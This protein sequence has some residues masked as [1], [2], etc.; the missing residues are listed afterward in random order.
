MD[1]KACYTGEDKTPEQSRP[2]VGK[3]M[4]AA[5]KDRL[6]RTRRSFT[7]PCSVVKSLK[8][9][10]DELPQTSAME[11]TP[12]DEDVTDVNRNETG[13]EDHLK[14]LE[15]DCLQRSQ[16]ELLQL[17]EKLKKDVKE[18][19][20][21]LRRLNM[22]KM[23]RKKNDLTQLQRLIDK[24]RKCAQEALYEL[25]TELPTNDQKA[26]LSQLIDHFGLEDS[27]LHFNRTEEDFTNG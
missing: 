15:S 7:S 21:M 3:P 11:M 27:I 2:S 23:Y 1:N 24:W 13:R 19:S 25:Q 22:V 10:E 16:C 17:R 18:K 9:Y 6:K 5:L 14:S 26:S 8:I 12:G 4:S 20:E